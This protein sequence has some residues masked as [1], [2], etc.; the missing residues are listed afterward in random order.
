MIRHCFS[1]KCS[2]FGRRVEFLR[3]FYICWCVTL[4]VNS[5]AQHALAVSQTRWA[6]SLSTAGSSAGLLRRHQPGLEARLRLETGKCLLVSSHSCWLLDW[7]SVSVSWWLL[8]RSH[9]QFIS[10]W[11]SP[12]AALHYGSL[13][14][15]SLQESGITVLCK[16]ITNI[17]SLL[18]YSFG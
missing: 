1:V 13:L 8:A 3:R 15:Q 12:Q 6:G 18:L 4:A 17:L 7:G 5:A 9:P 2:G 10:T 11:F 14:F 16:V